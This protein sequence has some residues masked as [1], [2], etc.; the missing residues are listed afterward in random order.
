MTQNHT[1]QGAKLLVAILDRGRALAAAG[2]CGQCMPHTILPAR[3]TAN[4][5]LLDYLG[6]ARNAKEIL[7]VL[8]APGAG[9]MV[10]AK[11]C[12]KVGVA[13]AG[14]RHCA[15]SAAVWCK[16]PRHAVGAAGGGYHTADGRAE[17]NERKTALRFNFGSG[18]RGYD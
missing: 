13:A 17:N 11:Y 7:L 10:V 2:L 1:Q 12:A 16:Q 5:E 14:P 3:G 8:L 15:D 4:S 9:G 6:L 18:E